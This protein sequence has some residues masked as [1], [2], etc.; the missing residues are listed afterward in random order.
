VAV[1]A[2]FQAAD[3]SSNGLSIPTAKIIAGEAATKGARHAHSIHGAIGISHACNL[4]FFT[5]RLW[6]WRTEFGSASFWS[7]KLGV[8]AA[9]RGA[10]AMWPAI[11]SGRWT[12]NEA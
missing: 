12:S 9:A 5:R 3:F 8:Q 2:A 11:T 6:S 4:N 1:D 10:D 7:K